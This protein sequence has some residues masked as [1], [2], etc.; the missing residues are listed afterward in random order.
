[1]RI[2]LRRVGNQ[3]AGGRSIERRSHVNLPA[4]VTIHC[5]HQRP[6]VSWSHSV[7]I[8]FGL[9]F[10]LFI[11]VSFQLLANEKHI[12]T[13]VVIAVIIVST[14]S[15]SQVTATKQHLH[16]RSANDPSASLQRGVPRAMREIDYISV[17]AGGG[18]IKINAGFF[19]HP[20]YF[21]L[22]FFWPLLLIWYWSADAGQIFRGWMWMA[23]SGVKGLSAVKP[24]RSVTRWR[25]AIDQKGLSARDC[26]EILEELWFVTTGT[27]SGA[28][29]A[30]LKNADATVLVASRN[31][32]T[33]DEHLA[34][35][36]QD[37]DNVAA[38]PLP[39]RNV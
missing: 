26:D 27:A 21:F 34:K 37:L 32:F 23:A 29:S 18:R 15:A 8:Q 25:C 38:P 30:I 1:M 36:D 3:S 5:V 19:S 24:I 10:S 9:K 12:I 6:P 39:K 20:F 11:W 17:A 31:H 35:S 7:E 22:W 4:S 13:V 14:F 28:R 2:S 33:G 16:Q